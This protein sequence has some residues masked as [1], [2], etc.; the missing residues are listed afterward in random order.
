MNA[1]PHQ[2]IIGLIAAAITG[3]IDVRSVPLPGEASA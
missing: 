1:N 2:N 3:K